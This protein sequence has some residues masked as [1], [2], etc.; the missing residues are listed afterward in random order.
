MGVIIVLSPK[1]VWGLQEIVK[2]AFS[3]EAETQKALIKCLFLVFKT[4]ASSVTSLV[5]TKRANHIL[6][7]NNVYTKQLKFIQNKQELTILSTGYC[8]GVHPSKTSSLAKPNSNF[9]L[10]FSDQ[11]TSMSMSYKLANEL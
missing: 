9:N 1:F 6:S 11:F 10:L 5:S 4:T 8:T 3:L 2:V 7:L